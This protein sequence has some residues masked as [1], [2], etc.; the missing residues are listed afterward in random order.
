MAGFSDIMLAIVLKVRM[1]VMDKVWMCVYTHRICVVYLP[2][3]YPHMILKGSGLWN[4]YT[5]I[6]PFL[7]LSVSVWTNRKYHFWWILLYHYKIKGEMLS[8]S[9]YKYSHTITMHFPLSTIY[10]IMKCFSIEHNRVKMQIFMK[11]VK[12]KYHLQGHL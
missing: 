8:I 1:S 12:E 3:S 7:F 11:Y 5:T 4:F 9:Q 2:S 10:Y 6:F